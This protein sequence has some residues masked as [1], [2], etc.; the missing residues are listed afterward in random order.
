MWKVVHTLA[1]AVLAVVLCVPIAWCQAT[2]IYSSVQI[3]SSP[4]PIG[5]GARAQGMGGAFIAVADD[6]TAASWNPG[7]LMQ[8]ERPEF[9]FVLSFD[10]RRRDFRSGEFPEASGMNEGYRQDLNYC[11]VALP[12]RVFD[13]NMIVSLN[14]QRLY[15]FYDDISFSQHISGASS[16]GVFSDHRMH[17][18]FSQSGALKAIAPAFAV[19]ITPRF[20]VGLTVNFWTDNLG[21]DN[22]WTNTRVTTAH[23]TVHAGPGL[24]LKSAARQVV[25]EKNEDFEGINLN[26]GFLWQVT[27]AITL[28][29]VVKTPFTA[30]IDRTTWSLNEVV[31]DRPLVPGIGSG[32][33]IPHMSRESVRMRMPLSCGLGIAVR[34]SDVFTLACD[35]YRTNWS[36][37]WIESGGRTVSPITNA[38]RSRSHVHDTTQVRLGCEYLFV[39]EKTIVPLRLGVFYDP[40]PSSRHPDDFFGVSLGTGVMLGPV[41]LD[42]AYVYRWARGVKGD[43]LSVPGTDVD[44]D[45]HSVYASLIYHF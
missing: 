26:A 14:Y 25:R 40:E 15:D 30:D 31:R 10:H 24:L 1:A 20:S 5:S 4:N 6:A 37:F 35:V 27:R 44:V 11:S 33:R 8:L 39:G 38:R 13:R 22:G 36:G 2:G 41:V 12:L 21:G 42:C 23:S 9:S 45:Q 43:V 19:Q 18:S 29:G 34:F 32:A 7:G 17:T 16:S 28:G 3:N